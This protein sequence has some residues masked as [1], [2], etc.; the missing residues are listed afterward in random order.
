MVLHNGYCFS[1]PIDCL[2]DASTPVKDEPKPSGNCLGWC[3]V[4]VE[5]KCQYSECIGCP[6]CGGES[7]EL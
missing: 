1:T 5:A 2:I 7:N 6:E 3:A 4:N